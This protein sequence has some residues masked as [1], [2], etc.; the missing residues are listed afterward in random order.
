MI[1]KKEMSEFLDRL[2]GPEGCDFR[3]PDPD[4]VNSITWNCAG[5][6]DTSLSRRTLI[7]M[8]R[9]EEDIKEI[10]DIAATS[11]GYCDCE[12]TFNATEA[13]LNAAT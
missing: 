9:S 7:D 4:D 10:L 1:T 2:Q 5:D 3:Q 12:I 6:N 13:L 8:G 11:G